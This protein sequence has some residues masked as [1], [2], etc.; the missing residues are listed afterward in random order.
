LLIGAI[1]MALGVVGL[2]IDYDG[3]RAANGGA[4]HMINAA[5][6]LTLIAAGLI[7]MLPA[8]AMEIAKDLPVFG[9]AVTAVWPG[10][11][12]DS[13]PPAGGGG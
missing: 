3:I 7:C 4:L 2:L 13:D 6:E 11:R 12:R 10:G 8:V 1:L 9:K 5:V